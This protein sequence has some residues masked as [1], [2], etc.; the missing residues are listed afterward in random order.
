MIENLGLREGKR[1]VRV[2]EGVRERREKERGRVR[3]S[4]GSEGGSNI[5]KRMSLAH[6][7]NDER[8]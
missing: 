6:H 8:I 5:D 1:D 7:K 2:S 4:Y 3:E